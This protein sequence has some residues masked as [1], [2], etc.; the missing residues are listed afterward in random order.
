M[1]IDDLITMRDE[2][3][4]SNNCASSYPRMVEYL[5]IMLADRLIQQG[6][7]VMGEEELQMWPY[8]EVG[9]E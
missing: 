6:Y 3:L 4:Q 2:I 7:L 1:T 5:G 8:H 9:I